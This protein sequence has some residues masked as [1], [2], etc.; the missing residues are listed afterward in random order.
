MVVGDLATTVDVIILGAGPGGYVAALRAA[1]L[2][3]EVVLV[4]PGPPGGVCL[5][6]GCIPAKALLNAAD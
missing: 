5:I 6:E 2:G 4:D 1:Q 3:K